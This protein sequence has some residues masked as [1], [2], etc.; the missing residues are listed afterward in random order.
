M[1]PLNRAERT[2]AFWRFLLLFV[3]TIAVVVM[4]TFFSFQVPLRENKALREKMAEIENE[5]TLSDRFTAKARETM[6]ELAKYETAEVSPSAAF[7]SVGFRIVDLNRLLNA[8]PNSENS[9]YA[10]ALRNIDDLNNTKKQLRSA[11]PR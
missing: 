3:I 10:L 11:P 5:R 7:V 6:T 9:I 4:A 2:A 1:Q 8:I